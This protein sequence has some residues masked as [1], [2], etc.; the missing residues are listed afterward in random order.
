MIPESTVQFDGKPLLCPVCRSDNIH[1]ARVVINQNG[2]VTTVK[3]N[4]EFL[5]DDGKTGQDGSIV[6]VVFW[7]E[8]QHQFTHEY[9]FSKGQTFTD[10]RR[11]PDFVEGSTSTDCYRGEMWRKM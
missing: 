4:G 3:E 1:L 2:Y 8:Q 11:L 7:C 6:T 9:E 5:R 10:W